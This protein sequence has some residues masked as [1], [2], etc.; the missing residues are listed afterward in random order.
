VLDPVSGKAIAPNTKRYGKIMED[1]LHT[2]ITIISFRDI[3]NHQRSYTIIVA[4]ISNLI[5]ILNRPQ[6]G[7]YSIATIISN[8]KCLSNRIQN[9]G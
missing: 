9:V 8:F 5:R 2:L 4:A 3:S 1:F 6:N 7:F